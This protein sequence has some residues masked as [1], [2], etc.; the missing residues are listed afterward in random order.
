MPGFSICGTGS[1][2]ETQAN[3]KVET[4]RKY[5][6]IMNISNMQQRAWAYLKTANR[7]KLS[8]GTIEQYHNQEKIWHEGK[9]NWNDLTCS[10]Y[11]VE[12]QPDVSKTIYDWLQST[13]YDIPGANAL[14]PRTYKKNIELSMLDHTGERHTESWRYCNAWPYDVDWGNLDYSSE[15]LCEVAVIF[16]YDRAQK[17]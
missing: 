12:Q 14:H 6:W 1:Q 2:S 8:L 11:D 13:T 3:G 10:F 15:E 4:R 7:P 5:R 16:K 17:I 9:T